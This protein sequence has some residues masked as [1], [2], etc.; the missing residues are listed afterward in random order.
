M[1]SIEKR[2]LLAISIILLKMTRMTIDEKLAQLLP[3]MA[4]I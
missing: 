4:K 2:R 3:F 1:L